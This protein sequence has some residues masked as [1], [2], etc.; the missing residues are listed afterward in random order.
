M[1]NEP[2]MSENS[3]LLWNVHNKAIRPLVQ[4]SSF[5]LSPIWLPDNQTLIVSAWQTGITHL[6]EINAVQQTVYSFYQVNKESRIV[7]CAVSPDGNWL[8]FFMQYADMSL[9]GIYVI[10]KSGQGFH[11]LVESS[12]PVS[13]PW[14]CVW[15]A[16]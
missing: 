7:P 10:H 9:A 15:L 12:G 13:D 16:K 1:T 11:P 14:S 4:E 2:I 6:L 8:V 3:L 5:F